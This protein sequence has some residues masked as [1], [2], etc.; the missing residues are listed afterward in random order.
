MALEL[1]GTTGVNL[2]QDGTVTAAD[3]AA[4]AARS[5]F[6]AGAV[7]QV[8][9]D[10]YTTQISSSSTS[11]IDTGLSATITPTAASSKTLILVSQ[12]IHARQTSSSDL[13][14][15][16][17]ILRQNDSVQLVGGTT[18]WFL[19]AATGGTYLQ[20]AE[21]SS[22]QFLDSPN[23]TSAVT[24]KFQTKIHLG[25]GSPTMFLQNASSPSMI[26]IMEIS[27]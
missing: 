8:V 7:L 18:S 21:N 14:V 22:F 1:N 19:C 3:L 10:V 13:I 12:H 6:G 4:G 27:A 16:C 17:R 2:I 23:T 5:N 15:A 9:S 26:T 24:Y 25:T 11:F 20:K